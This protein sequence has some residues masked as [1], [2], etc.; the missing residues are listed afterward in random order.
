MLGAL[1]AVL[2]SESGSRW[3]LQQGLGMQQMLQARYQGGTILGGL[4]LADIRLHTAG[5]DLR[6]RHLL[7][8]WSLWQLLQGRIGLATLQAE[9]IDL[10]R[11][12]A[13]VPGPTR[14][15]TLFLPVHLV[16]EEARLADIR[17]WRWQ[18]SQPLTLRT[19]ALEEVH[20]RGTRVRF[21]QLVAEQESIGRLQ[22]QGRIQLRGG[23]PLQAE[24][25]LDYRPFQAQGWLPLQVRLDGAVA[26]L[27][28]ALASH[29]PLTAQAK[30]H[31][32][33]LQPELP[34]RAE[35]QW[36]KVNLPWWS[37]QSLSS[38]G[39]HLAVSG[40]HSGLKSQG[41]A[42]LAGHN[43]PAG[44]YAWMGRTDWHTA[45][46]DSLKFNGLG[47]K[48]K[49]EA[50]I[51]W[52]QG[53]DWRLGAV[54]DHVD[55]AQK[56]PVSH[57]VV[58]VLTGKLSSRGHTSSADSAIV[59][60]LQLAGGESWDL[61][62]SGQSWPWNL[63][64]GQQLTARWSQVQRQLPS[65]QTIASESGELQAGGTRQ[66]YQ[67]R[68]DAR[69]GG[70]R[71]PASHVTA[72]IAGSGLQLAVK[73][74]AYDGE[75]GRLGF[76]GEL[77]FGTP[78]R[79][80][81]TLTPE[82]FATGALLPDWPGQLSGRISGQGVW[83]GQQRE[84]HLDEVHLEGRLKEQALALDGPLDI[85]LAPAGGWPGVRSPSLNARWGNNQLVAIGGLRDGHWD[86]SAQLDLGDL[87]LL[88]PELRGKLQGQL[89]L[90]GAER[91]PDIQASLTGTGAGFGD[92]RA[93]AARLQATVQAL[94]DDNSQVS[95]DVDGLTNA[96]DKDWGHVAL[97]LAGTRRQHSLDWRAESD[98]LGGHGRLAGSWSEA[99]WDGRMEAGVV[100]LAGME[101]Q[102]A[103]P[104]ALAWS[105]PTR[106]L[107]LDDFCWTSGEASLCNEDRMV[108]GPA[109]HIRLALQGLQLERLA[110]FMPEGLVLTGAVAGSAIGD[111]QPGETPVVQARLQARQGEFRLARDEGQKPL[112]RGYDLIALEADA[113][114]RSVDLRFELQSPDMGQGRVQAR[115]DPRTAGKPLQGELAL[116]GLRL[117]IFQPFFPAL[118]ELTGAVSA[119]G[120][121]GGLLARPDFHGL[122]QVQNGELGFQ[123]LPLHVRDLNTRIEV[124]G[125]SAD[126]SGSMKSG[127]G[128]ARL[129]GTAD[130]SGQPR[131][132]LDLKGERFQLRQPPELLAEVNPDLHLQVVPGRADLTGTVRVPMARLNL[133]PLTE[134]AV[135]LS[136]D[137]QIVTA[138]DRERAVVVNRAAGWDINADIRLVLGD[139]VYFHGYGVNGR[140]LG[141]LRLR[142]EGR[143]GLEA[144]GEV[145]LDKEARYDAYGQRLQI[146]R[147]RLIFA[148]NLTQPGLDV[149]AIREVDG[150]V[151]GVRVQGRANAP[152][153][154]LFSD[155]SMSQ[156]EIVSYLVLGRP[157]DA[158]GR[159]ESGAGNLTAAAAAIKLGATGGAGLT[160][161]VGE[162]LGITDLSVDAEGSGDDTQFTVSGYLSPKL[163]LRYGVGIFT[164]VNTVTLRYKINAK[165][166]LEAVSS[167][168][169]AIDLF[170][171][172]R[173]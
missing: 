59:A 99:G 26:D 51:S 86:L 139:D 98:R 96:V 143:R 42:Q 148:G 156:E 157:L 36:Q 65:G 1:L 75:A 115:I 21:R 10:H 142:Q 125:T 29:G 166:Y 79:W 152:E 113:G 116:Q 15:P 19:L 107:R 134:Q 161:K 169:S 119:Q 83:G 34:F 151:V 114:T 145:E 146:R 77:A 118:S 94:G 109:G 167:L 135:P 12:Q 8:R 2:G 163:Y 22:L 74:L 17:F 147:G 120:R 61:Q 55:L 102:L 68:L 124:N 54:L 30:G 97:A 133:K 39:G 121:L 154:T 80:Q 72:V 66:D 25:Q 84:F 16:V 111:W 131:L 57:E 81:G 33:P 168:E 122:V 3:L 95:L 13:P 140:L 158:S 149:E 9:G 165:L 164:P 112:V 18:A 110:G 47:G 78:L 92:W 46:I 64:A 89:A 58:P 52:R 129:D 48:V 101:W 155:E 60:S 105:R 136:P 90:Q 62:Q 82:G 23:Y 4:E 71:L 49:A 43:L 73:Q 27:D 6:V 50:D 63:Q 41:E 104:F 76:Q 67:A 85:A 171:N 159:P 11:L 38:R 5:T 14:L 123:R 32:R 144:N 44:Q 128:G 37:D 40:D 91:R 45:H 172:F 100:S 88:Y 132:S 35:L 24:G 138:A 150:K 141:S 127:D 160:N 93:R 103:S 173:F 7:A 28:V 106:Q 70:G 117:D 137:V 162:S 20:W 130:W 53:L 31:I 56:W 126:I 108:L 69:L 87:Q 170:Y 153:A